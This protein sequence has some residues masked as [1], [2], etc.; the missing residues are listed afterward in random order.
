M[1]VQFF[2]CCSTQTPTTSQGSENFWN[3]VAS[4]WPHFVLRRGR[5]S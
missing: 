5:N 2:V 1:I 3:G 4:R